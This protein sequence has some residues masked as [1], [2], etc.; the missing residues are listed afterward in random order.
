MA[1]KI[2]CADFNNDCPAQFTAGE[3]DEL[4]QHVELHTKAAHQPMEWTPEL[5][6]V[7]KTHLQPA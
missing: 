4:L 6:E 1:V 7:V 2:R 3:E 5:V